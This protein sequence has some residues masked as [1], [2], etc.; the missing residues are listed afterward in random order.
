[1]SVDRARPAL[2][3]A[4]AVV[5]GAFI[6]GVA[7]SAR[8]FFWTREVA[9]VLRLNREDRE[10]VERVQA[11]LTAESGLAVALVAIRGALRE[12][13][14]VPP[15]VSIPANGYNG[16]GVASCERYEVTI[17]RLESGLYSLRS[18]GASDLSPPHDPYPVFTLAAT[19]RI[20]SSEAV[21]LEVTP[22]R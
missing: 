12:E 15:S 3:F 7:A 13:R 22:S 19:A 20:T 1:M 11:R 2:L 6:A 5:A 10:T 4:T 14:E 16:F 9:R 8:F 18:T 17:E 21:L